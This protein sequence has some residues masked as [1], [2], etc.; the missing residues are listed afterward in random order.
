MCYNL[1][2]NDIDNP[3]QDFVISALYQR[4]YEKK[5]KTELSIVILFFH[6]K[7]VIIKFSIE[8]FVTI[9]WLGKVK[10]GW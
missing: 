2:D 3:Y 7:Q 10:I 6:T 5:I 9:S 1:L 4:D 8:N